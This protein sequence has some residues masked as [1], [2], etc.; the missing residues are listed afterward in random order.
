MPAITRSATKQ[1]KLEE[2]KGTKTNDKGPNHTRKRKSL[3]V[4]NSTS[5]K[6][7]GRSGCSQQEANISA[8]SDK[9]S[10]QHNNDSDE[11]Q[12]AITITRAPVLELWASCVA[13]FIYPS[14]SWKTCLSVGGAIST[15]TAV[16]KGRSI[17]TIE[18]PD[19]GKAEERRRERQ[20]KAENEQLEDIEAMGFHLRLKDGQAL[21]GDKPKAGNEGALSKKFGQD[22]YEMAK[23]AFQNAMDSWKGRESELDREAFKMYEEFRPTVP[24]GQKGWG[25]KGQLN[26]ESVKSAIGGH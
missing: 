18:K 20:Q 26:L 4:S 22:Q 2:I 16:A 7:K 10:A 5:K 8:S 14:A 13:Q 21:V 6:Q 11:G 17:G 25:R 24:P 3:A 1:P 12:V 19:P 15:I 23:R 9:G